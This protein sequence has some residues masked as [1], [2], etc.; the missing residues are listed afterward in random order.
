MRLT[1]ISLHS[2]QRRLAVRVRGCKWIVR[3]ILSFV[4]ASAYADDFQVIR[5]RGVE[6]GFE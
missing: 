6:A 1:N 5:Q 4:K 2:S 3:D